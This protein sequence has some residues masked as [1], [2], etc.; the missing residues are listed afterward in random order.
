MMRI[1][2]ENEYGRKGLFG[3]AVLLTLVL[4][5][6]G[7]ALCGSDKAYAKK[8]KVVS[9]GS[10]E[11]SS[12][13]DYDNLKADMEEW[14]KNNYSYDIKVVKDINMVKEL[15]QKKF[16]EIPDGK[17]LNFDLGN[18]TLTIASSTWLFV[19]GNA[20]LNFEGGTVKIE[21]D[22][23]PK[24]DDTKLRPA[25]SVS[26]GVVNVDSVHFIGSTDVSRGVHVY[27]IITNG[28]NLIQI[29]NAS[30]TNN[31]TNCIFENYYGDVLY[32]HNSQD[33]NYNGVIKPR[34]CVTGC[35]FKNNI[36]VHG[37]VFCDYAN[38]Y[39][40]DSIFTGNK[41]HPK[42]VNSKIVKAASAIYIENKKDRSF[43]TIA[44]SSILQDV[45]VTGNKGIDHANKTVNNVEVPDFDSELPVPAVVNEYG[46]PLYLSGTVVIADN[47]E[48]NNLYGIISLDE[49]KNDNGTKISPAFKG[50]EV[51]ISKINGELT[52]SSEKTFED[53]DID[54]EVYIDSGFYEC[55][56]DTVM[57]MTHKEKNGKSYIEY[58][59]A[60]KSKYEELKAAAST[61][62]EDSEDETEE[63]STEAVTEE[64]AETDTEESAEI[65]E[66]E[67][68]V[69]EE[70]TIEEASDEIE[71]ISDEEGEAAEQ[72]AEETGS[73]IGGGSSTMALAGLMVVLL[74]GAGGIAYAQK[75][76]KT[77]TEGSAKDDNDKED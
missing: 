14:Y 27:S 75:K 59:L 47:G 21:F 3:A 15:S 37:A 19:L 23:T 11:L 30:K 22:D 54:D 46:S 25:I 49:L 64:T 65:S 72:E 51:V 61:T 16:I 74:A 5:L 40:K 48:G 70:E 43:T 60:K 28:L 45:T 34:V 50:G 10:F 38:I 66:E 58:N 68:A 52:R 35:E 9:T 12:I 6:A 63:E 1:R 20:T 56:K 26:N 32:V 36:C 73:A 62:E 44:P 71:E 17:T 76:K 57:Y 24:Y 42:T 4:L 41:T 67:Q 55:Y 13:S 39:I 31:I 7:I 8:K 33:F 29:T 77:V 18:H 2:L 53:Y 69:D